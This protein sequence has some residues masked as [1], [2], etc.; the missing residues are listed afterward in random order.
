MLAATRKANVLFTLALIGILWTGD[1]RAQAPLTDLH[2]DPLPSGAALRLGTVR[3]RPAPTVTCVVFSP[4]G[5]TL[6]STSYDKTVRL[7]DADTGKEQR[8]LARHAQHV[9]GAAF[10]PDGKS[11][12]FASFDGTVRIWDVSAAKESRVLTGHQQ[13][14]HA[15]AF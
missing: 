13:A 1:G 3:F 15:L 14:V 4:D 2:G 9:F 10:S 8:V 5:N 11:I 12:A 7:W 6:V